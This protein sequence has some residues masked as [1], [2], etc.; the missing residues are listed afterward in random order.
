VTQTG[1]VLQGGGALGAYELGALKRLY[2]ES[3]FRPSIISGVSIGAITA[4]TLVGGKAGPIETLEAL[5]R[6]FS[7]PSS[8]LVPETAQHFL[9]LFGDLGFFR[10]RTDYING[11]SWTSFYDTSPLRA[12]LME[13]IDFEK[14]QGS[15]IKLFV[16]A[17]N[18]A[19]GRV[20]VFDNSSITADHILASG[21][22][23]PGFPMIEIN[24]NFYWDGGVFD[25]SPL[26]AVIEHL[27]PDP[28][29]PKQIVVIDLFPG[30]GPVP[31][32]MLDV[33][34]RAFAITF[35][36]K[37]KSDLKQAAKVNEYIDVIKA[38]DGALPPD[39]PVRRLPGYVRLTQ[40]SFVDDI[41]YIENVHPEIVFGP[42]D[43]SEQSIERRMH[44]GYRDA[45][46]AIEAKPGRVLR[47]GLLRA[48]L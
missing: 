25:N 6:R 29:V 45:A 23:P 37:F 3:N 48:P 4:A 28:N 43:F 13:F 18:V 8:P 27:N 10:L 39:H 16:T 30:P 20:E 32:N 24:H 31:Q 42:F 2:E 44:A 35:S 5:W 47:R 34:G 26:G 33:F 14:I 1:L 40:Y 22:L 46:A 21:A 9:A 36:N 11:A 38:I 12:T 17:A 41:I 15:A 7:M 19:T